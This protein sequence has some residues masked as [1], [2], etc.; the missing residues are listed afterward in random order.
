MAA[1]GGDQRQMM[2]DAAKDKFPEG[3]RVLTVDDDHAYLK[4]LYL[5]ISLNNAHCYAATMVMDA[6]TALKMLRAEKEQFHLVITDVR[7]PDMDGFKLLE[8]IGLDMDLPVIMLSV[9]CDKKA[10]MKGINHGVCD[11]L[12]K[13]VHTNE[14]KNIW[15]HV[16]SRRRC[17]AISHMSRDND[18]DQ[19]VHPKTLAKNKDSKSKRNE[20]DGSNENKESTR[21]APNKILELMNVDCLTRHNIASHLQSTQIHTVMQVKDRNS[22]M[23]NQK[24]FMHNHRHERW[25]VQL[26]QLTDS[27][28]SLCMGSLIHGGRMSKY[29]VPHTL[30]ARRFAGSED[31]PISLDNGILDDI[32]L[33]EFSS[34]SSGTSYVDSMC[35]KLME[36]SKG[37]NPSNHQSYF[38]NTPSGRGSLAPTN[39]YQVNLTGILHRGGTSHVPPRVNIPRIDQLTNYETSSSGLLLQNQLLPFIGNTTSVKGFSEKIVPFNI[40]NNPSSVGM[41]NAHN[42]TP[43][44]S[45]QMFGGGR[46]TTQAT[47]SVGTMLNGNFAHGTSSTSKTET[48]VVSCGRTISTLTNLQTDGFVALTP[49][50]DGGDAS[51]IL[52]VQ[53]SMVNQQEPND[54]LND[55]NAFSSD[56]IAKLLNDDFIGEDV[57]MD[58]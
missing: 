15:Q 18:D 55:I 6:K 17:Q 38:T 40:P 44:A 20:K 9:D 13:P 51:G 24:N 49:M 8:L 25:H 39:E 34:Y 11:F 30:D 14:L 43:M 56:D 42:S 41:L 58:G 12:M 35:G 50:L 7:M 2:E 19:R 57:V 4:V 45:S 53:E 10:M 27:Q 37:K 46:I 47:S 33:D 54:L 23:V 3:L 36:T 26:G 52:L 22:S 31:A 16:E 32:M 28:S 29:L 5:F 48:N 21:A 1:I